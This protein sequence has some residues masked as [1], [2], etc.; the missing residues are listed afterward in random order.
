M[1]V[2]PTSQRR[3]AGHPERLGSGAGW[4][5]PTLRDG[6]AKDGA[7]GELGRAGLGSGRG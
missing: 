1:G 4:W 3:D 5:D 2:Q 7:P 6:A